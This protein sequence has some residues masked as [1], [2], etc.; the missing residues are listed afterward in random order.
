[1]PGMDDNLELPFP[2]MNISNKRY[3]VTALVTSLN[4]H[5]EKIA[6]L[7]SQRCGKS[8]EVH[9]IMKE[10][11]A[12]RFPSSDFGEN[13]CRWWIMILTLNIQSIM[14]QLVF[15]KQWKTTFL[16]LSHFTQIHAS[17]PEL[18]LVFIF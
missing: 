13:A 8:E 5:G 16:V 7:Y 14:K 15:G 9:S 18:S 6:H 11:S 10:D 1:M 3:K 17:K 2:K 4:W 12:G